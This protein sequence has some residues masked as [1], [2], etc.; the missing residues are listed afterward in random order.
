MKISIIIPAY[1]EEKRIIPTLESYY[2]FFKPKFKG[3][4]EIIVIP[5]NCKD[6]TFKIVKEFIKNKNQIKI[7]NIPNYSG[8]G[9]A[10]IKGFEIA[11]GDYIGFTD[12]DNSTNP[13]NFYKLFKNIGK[14]DG[15]I[16]SRRKKGAIVNPPRKIKQDLSSLCFN[17]SVRFLFN[18][19]YSD[20]QCGA[21]LFKKETAKFL[22]NNSSEKGWIFDVDWL[23]L[24]KKNNYN[25]KEYPI[26]WRDSEGSK[27]NMKDGILSFFDLIK[28]KFNNGL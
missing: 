2:N 26:S 11:K 15:I 1:N 10:V 4:L 19:N 25:I 22:A 27:L 3:N 28:Y 24:C 8:K 9:G 21:K 18:L 20:T 7:I 5:N 14:F 17:L 6:N 12:A 23:Y 13:E 16:A